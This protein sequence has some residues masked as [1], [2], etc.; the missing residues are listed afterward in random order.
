MALV[1]LA[2]QEVLIG[3]RNPCDAH[4]LSLSRSYRP[5][6]SNPYRHNVFCVCLYV[7]ALMFSCKNF[8]G[9]ALIFGRQQLSLV[10]HGPSS[11]QLST[12][13]ANKYIRYPID[14]LSAH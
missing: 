9:D 1:P 8:A 7:H 2:L 13:G 11:S 4:S 6:D 3:V 14:A 10:I 12:L 5:T